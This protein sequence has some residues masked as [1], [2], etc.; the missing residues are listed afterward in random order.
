VT[1]TFDLETDAH[2]ARE[3][4]KL[5]TNFGVLDRFVLNLSA[6]TYQTRHATLRP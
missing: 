4:N 2:Y 3:V 1:L 5:L 6:N